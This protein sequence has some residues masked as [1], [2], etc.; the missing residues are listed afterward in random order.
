MSKYSISLNDPYF[1]YWYP[2]V[3]N[4]IGTVLLQVKQY[5]SLLTWKSVGRNSVVKLHERSMNVG[6]SVVFH[7]HA[8]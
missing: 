3:L 7:F 1:E 4:Y 6:G 5:C 8:L 2:F